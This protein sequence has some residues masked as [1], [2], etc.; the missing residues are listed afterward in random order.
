MKQKFILPIILTFCLTLSACGNKAPSL[1]EVEAAI[2]D[3]SVTIQ[4]ALDKGWITQEWADSY[5]EDNSV[6]A[7]DKISIN[8]VGDFETKTLDGN[9]FTN[10]DISN[11]AFLAFIDP[12]DAGASAFYD[13]LLN[14]ADDVQT[15]GASI[16]VCNKGSMDT[17]LFQNPPFPVI[18]YNDSMK[19]ALAQN[20]AMASDLPCVGVWYVN[21][22]LISAWNTQVDADELSDSA[23]SFVTMSQNTNDEPTEDGT[24]A[25]PMG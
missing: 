10:E 7:A 17:T 18:A 16:V 6:P 22:S 3:G 5:L 13:A 2:R 8:M 25:I 4:D 1:D 23:T 20:D 15:A 12:D 11:T 21:G 24:T 19:T 9:T 14:A